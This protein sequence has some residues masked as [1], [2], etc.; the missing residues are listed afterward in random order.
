MHPSVTS[1]TFGAEF[2]VCSPLS[3]PALA[4]RITEL[5]GKPVWADYGSAPTAQHWKIV[6]DGSIR[7]AGHALEVVSPVLSGQAGLDNVASV[8]NALKAIGCSVNQTTGMHVHV[9][10]PTSRID[11]FKDLLKLYGRFEDA[12]DSLMP[13]SR[14]AN[15]AFY[16]RTVKLNRQAIEQAQTVSDLQRAQVRASG[17]QSAKYHKVNLAPLGK[18]TVEFRQHNGTVNATAA[19]NWISVCLRL[20]AL[21]KEGQIGEGTANRVAWDLARLV[22]K[23]ADCARLIA[24]PE[25]ATNNEIRLA[26][27]YRTIS[28]RKQL[29]DA[30]LPFREVRDSATGKSRFFA[31]ASEVQVA[32]GVPNYAPTVDGLADLIEADAEQKAYLAERVRTVR[33]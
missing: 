22:G 12:I 16:C 3:R 33:A 10:R 1:L 24:R 2:E 26:C 13:R 21:A 32:G 8:V 27:G 15:A 11:F 29:K 9:G 14:R 31:A 18:P 5:S 30:G 17:A 25:G 7:G 6:S 28:A 4:A 19:V 20:V 23:Q